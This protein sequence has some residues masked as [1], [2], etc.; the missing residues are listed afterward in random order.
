MK[1]LRDWMT[2]LGPARRARVDARAA[3]IFAE[4]MSLK[5]L[6]KAR[7]IIR[8]VCR[9]R[10]TLPKTV[11]PES[12]SAPICCFQRCEKASRLWV[13][14]FDWLLSFMAGRP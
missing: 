3:E 10:L 13:V 8:R 11:C 7:R 1:T 12:N 9:S 4:E 6:R 14:T 2:E 5:D